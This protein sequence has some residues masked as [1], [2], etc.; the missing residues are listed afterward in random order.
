MKPKRAIAHKQTAKS[1]VSGKAADYV[2]A[3]VR[4]LDVLTCFEAGRRRMTLSQVAALTKLSRGTSR[5]LLLTL[6]AAGYVH[7][8]GKSFWLTPKVLQLAKA[9]L[10]SNGLA[11][12]ARP[13]IRWVTEETGESCS[14][15]VLD[16]PDIVYIA[17]VE[18]RR[19]FSSGLEPG[20]RLPAHCASLGQ[21]LLAELEPAQLDRWLKD[22]PLVARTSKTI[23]DPE[24]LRLK[25]KEV[26]EQRFAM[27]DGELEIGLRSVAVPIIGSGGRALAAI[28]IGALET[29]VSHEKMW[30]DFVPVLRT[31]A[32]EIGEAAAEL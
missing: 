20:T 6:Q 14:V 19:I 5:R 16:G 22:Y 30:R 29:R 10:T 4:G 21:A 23:T 27:C 9:F 8:D 15:A 25:L 13:F 1:V 32:R 17:R 18:T 28:N 3:L 2:T 24:R 12:V 26:A 11:E 7:G 31:A